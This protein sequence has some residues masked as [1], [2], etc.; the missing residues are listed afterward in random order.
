M[1]R[2][3]ATCSDCGD[4]ELTT[5]DVRLRVCNHDDRGSYSFVCP[6]C[7]L[8]VAKEAKPHVIDILVASGVAVVRWDLPLE[9]QEPHRGPAITHDDLLDFHELLERDELWAGT[10]TRPTRG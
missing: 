6:G 3:R 9:L 5:A 7:R 8:A 2:I 4:V 1:A 10:L